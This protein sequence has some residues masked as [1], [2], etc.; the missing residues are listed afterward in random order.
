MNF[1]DILEAWEQSSGSHKIP[2]PRDDDIV[3]A[4]Q[5]V[6]VAPRRLPI[7][8]TLDLH[9][10]RL[11]EAISAVE[12]FIADGLSAGYRKLLIIHGKGESSGAVLR[13]EVRRFL[14][15]H[16]RVGTTGD[17]DGQNGGRGAVWLMLRR[18]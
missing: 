9:G 6:P 11:E 13:K 2:T 5:R 16:P 14:E 10:Y 4:E 15:R 17:A 3:D 7:E 18:P 12:H 8:A 1:G